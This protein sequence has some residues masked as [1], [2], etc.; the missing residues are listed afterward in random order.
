MTKRFLACSGGGD[1]GIIMVGMLLQLYDIQGKDAVSWDEM[2]GISV[3]GFLV[4]YVSQTTP[5]TFKPMMKDMKQAFMK[6][7]IKVVEP[8]GWG[9]QFVNLVNAFFNHSS[10]YSNHTII[11]TI[12]K[13]FDP[14]RSVRPFHVGAYNK[15]RI[16][17]ETFSSTDS[18]V[19]IK[20]AMLASASVPVVLPEVKIGDCMYQ[21]GGMRHLIPVNE[22]KDWISRTDGKKHIDILVC[23]PIHKFNVFTKMS[24][25]VFSY[26]IIN[27][28]TRMISD[29]ML[30]QLILDLKEISKMCG[31]SYEE[32]HKYPCGKFE[33]GDTCIQILSPSDGHFTSMTNMSAEQ[34]KELFTEGTDIV[35]DFVNKLK[36]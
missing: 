13:W 25:P 28:S 16:E 29:L 4:A 2:A 21:D 3:G 31:I 5:D 20:Q 24:A 22:I 11:Q 27:E 6:N 9:G 36:I 1:K 35:K 26:P 10:L 14:A 17:Y 7:E 30:E 34:N 19:N 12:E 23:Y 32:I 8:W 33:M 15:T 18:R